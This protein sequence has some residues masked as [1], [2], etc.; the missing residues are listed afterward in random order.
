MGLLTGLLP[1]EAFPE[2]RYGVLS[3]AIASG[4]E[5]TYWL[6]EPRNRE[7]LC[8]DHRNPNT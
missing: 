2:S 5:V 3:S 6:C 8:A 4:E 7:L 1:G